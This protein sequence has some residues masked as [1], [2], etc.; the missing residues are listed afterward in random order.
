MVGALAGAVTQCLTLPIS[1]IT[2]RQQTR[3]RDP[4]RTKPDPAPLHDMATT[5]RQIIQQDGGG[6]LWRGLVP[7]LVLTSNPAIT[8]GL[9][10][11]LK[12]AW[13][14]RRHHLPASLSPLETFLLGVLCKTL[15]T[16]LTYPYIM[17]K[18]RM[19]WRAVDYDTNERVRYRNARDVLMKVLKAEGVSGWY[20]GMGAQI[21]KAVLT[22]ALLFV[23]KDQIV[24]V[25]YW[26]LMRARVGKVVGA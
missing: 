7:A 24:W 16:V 22:Q 3:V 20:R 17:A 26:M 14:T 12:R 9:F 19:Q 4:P 8:Y 6:G 11:R 1:V 10:E 21:S 23:I 2:T 13:L 18:V 5:A 25:T 15:A